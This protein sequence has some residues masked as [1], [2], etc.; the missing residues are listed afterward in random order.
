LNRYEVAL[1]ECRSESRGLTSVL[2]GSSRLA[3]LHALEAGQHEAV[4]NVLAGI[5]GPLLCGFTMWLI[6]RAQSSGVQRLYFLSRQGQ[7]LHELASIVNERLQLGLDLRYLYVS[8]RSLD[9]ALLA[10]SNESNL[11]CATT[12]T[13]SDSLRQILDRIGLQPVDIEPELSEIGL[14]SSAWDSPITPAGHGR[15][16]ELV[17]E[18]RP[19]SALAEGAAE[20]R[21]LLAEAYLEAQGLFD[22]LRIGLVD[23]TGIGSQ[24]RTLN[25]LRRARVSADTEGFLIVRNWRDAV[26]NDGFP[27]IHGY[28]ADHHQKRGYGALPGVVPVLE[29]VT[30][31]D[32]GMTTGYQ[33]TEG[34]VEPILHPAS[35]DLGEAWESARLRSVIKVFMNE[36]V[37]VADSLRTERDA[38]AGV[39]EAFR[40]FWDTPTPEEA[41]F[42]G[43]FQYESGH[44]LIDLAPELGVTDILNHA[45]GKKSFSEHWFMW[46]AAREQRSPWPVRGLLFAARWMNRAVGRVRKITGGGSRRAQGI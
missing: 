15:L 4:T 6:E 13:K 14:S 28:L 29:I 16:V 36:F 39:V 38:R 2:A 10:T 22:C 43:S 23:A 34:I 9:L 25:L 18:D 24:L 35:T 8:R 5:A 19:R 1:E 32:H 27:P 41:K 26:E 17:Q 45:L 44:G 11:A 3:R 46:R 37:S 12:S 42:W 7:L 21:E 31:T 20:G 33:R 30:R 40:K